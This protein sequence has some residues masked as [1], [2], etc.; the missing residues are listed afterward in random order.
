MRHLPLYQLRVCTMHLKRNLSFLIVV[1]ISIV[2]VLYIFQNRYTLTALFCQTLQ[3]QD[4]AI[5]NFRIAIKYDPGNTYAYYQ[6][7][8]IYKE[9][10]DFPNAEHI[11]LKL[12]EIFPDHPYAHYDLGYVY[13]EM[14]LYDKAMEQYQ[15]ALD[16]DSQNTYAISDIGYIYKEQGRY[17]DALSQFEKVLAIE[18]YHKYALWDIAEVY[19]RMGMK[20]KAK[21]SYKYYHE[22]TECSF[23]RVWNCFD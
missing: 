23:R 13:R 7:G 14:K 4:K 11:Y 19:D 16:I 9:Q 6:L 21:E 20:D 17:E 8:V 10:K 18:P 12:L 2:L 22:M 1:V 5:E 3:K 15:R